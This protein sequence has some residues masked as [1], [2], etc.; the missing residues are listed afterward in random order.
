MEIREHPT[1]ENSRS[2]YIGKTVIIYGALIIIYGFIFEQLSF[3]VSVALF[4]SI[5]LGFVY[6]WYYGAFVIPS[7]I[8]CPKCDS[9][10]Q[11][12]TQKPEGFMVAVCKNCK[13]KWK[14]GHR[15]AND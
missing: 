1:F 10:T 6:S 4:L 5:F 8:T 7:K 13:I 2:R 12:K 15:F 3:K 11:N 9:A 14:L